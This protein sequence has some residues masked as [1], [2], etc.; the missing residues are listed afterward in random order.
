MHYSELFMSHLSLKN[1]SYT[2]TGNFTSVLPI[3]KKD[4]PEDESKGETKDEPV[5]EP[6]KVFIT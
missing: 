4:E 6:E 5:T 3:E 2:Y 1:N